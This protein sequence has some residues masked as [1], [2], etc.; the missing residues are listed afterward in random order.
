[1]IITFKTI[2][3]YLLLLS[4]CL[5]QTGLIC[6]LFYVALSGNVYAILL[7]I[8]ITYLYIKDYKELT[9]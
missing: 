7:L 3:L 9:C 5:I 2:G 8:L 4:L 6:Y 1:M